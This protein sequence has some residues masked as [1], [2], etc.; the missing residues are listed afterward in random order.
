VITNINEFSLRFD[1]VSGDMKEDTMVGVLDWKRWLV[2][3]NI[4]NIDW[5][6]E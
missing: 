3:V 1:Y 4:L 6:L 2:F 5:Q